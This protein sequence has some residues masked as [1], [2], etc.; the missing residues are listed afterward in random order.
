MSAGQLLKSARLAHGLTQAR[1]ALRAGTSQAAIS[2]IENGAVSP[3]VSTLEGLLALMGY[4]VELGLS[5]TERGADSGLAG[6][7]DDMT[8]ADRMG[9]AASW[10]NLVGSARR[11]DG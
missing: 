9:T 2:R 7:M 1:L 8:P 6:L 11:V 3:A 10:A 5:E 4:E